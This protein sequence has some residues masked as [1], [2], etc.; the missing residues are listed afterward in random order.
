[1]P[2]SIVPY[3]EQHIPAVKDFNQRL[4]NGGAPAD[5]VFSESHIPAW[6]PKHGV[7]SGAA[8]VYNEFYLALD[9]DAVRGAFVLKH[10]VFS[11]AGALKPLVY[12]HHP[13]SEGI[14]DK[15]YSQVGAQMLMRI[16]RQN[17]LLFALGMGGYDRPLPR[18]L[19]ALHWRHCLIPFQF[20]VCNGRQFLREMQVFRSSSLKRMLARS[21]AQT[22]VGPL[23]LKLWQG[24][25]GRQGLRTGFQAE[26]VAEFDDWADQIWTDVAAS[27]SMIAV[28]DARSLR[29][30][31]PSQNHRLTRIRVSEGGK[32][33]GWAVVGILHR[34]GHEQY[35]DLRVGTILDGL[36]GQEHATSVIAAAT[37]VLE[38]QGADLIGSNQSHSAWRSALRKCGF[39][40]GP[41]NFIFA[42][43]PALSQLLEPFYPTVDNAHLNRGD[44]DNLLQYK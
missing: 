12:L 38:E 7:C 34:T 1:M 23:M 25:R 37:R 6:L 18:M 29:T 33:V 17:P 32:I 14:V 8:P 19:L 13:F 24:F 20:R 30:L 41:S 4:R 21:A 31:Y 10:Q 16:V 26:V 35:G 42:V 3:A 9:R 11:F 36:S 43:G 28:R 2:I 22:G 27:Y 44:G 5:Y 39:L 15:R 40:N